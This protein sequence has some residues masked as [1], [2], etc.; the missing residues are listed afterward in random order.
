MSSFFYSTKN[1]NVSFRIPKNIS[2][3][4]GWFSF[5]F[6]SVWKDHLMILALENLIG[7]KPS[8][9]VSYVKYVHMTFKCTFIF[10]HTFRHSRDNLLNVFF[11]SFSICVKKDRKFVSGNG[12]IFTTKIILWSLS[13]L[14]INLCFSSDKFETSKKRKNAL[15]SCVL[16]NLPLSL[17]LSLF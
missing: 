12:N 5:Y 14:F 1:L 8:K 4:P 9:V 3:I 6:V 7:P 2:K 11:S 17:N 15:Y 13:G 16:D 10:L